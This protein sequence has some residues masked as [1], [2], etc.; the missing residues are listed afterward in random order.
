VQWVRRLAGS[1]TRL[2]RHDARESG[3]PARP[4]PPRPPQPWRGGSPRSTARSSSA[5]KRSPSGDHPSV[6]LWPVGT[7]QSQNLVLPSACCPVVRLLSV[8]LRQPD[9][10][11]GGHQISIWCI[12]SLEGR[13]LESRPDRPQ[14]LTGP[15]GG[16][17]SRG[18]ILGTLPALWPLRRL[19][20]VT[21]LPVRLL[22]LT[23]GSTGIAAIL[24]RYCN[25]RLGVR[26]SPPALYPHAS[27]AP[28]ARPP[29]SAT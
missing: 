11:T 24:E 4:V 19:F 27:F 17:A 7:A 1:A 6:D 15:P 26:V 14:A 2:A 22:A 28:E 13:S 12:G 20:R 5:S 3:G 18:T 25:S 10:L 8:V 21:V 9:R 16:A 29:H 23:C